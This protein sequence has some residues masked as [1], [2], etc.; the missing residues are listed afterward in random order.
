MRKQKQTKSAEADIYEAIKKICMYFYG[1]VYFKRDESYKETK[2]SHNANHLNELNVL[3][4]EM[5]KQ[6][7]LSGDS[8]KREAELNADSALTQLKPIKIKVFCI[9]WGLRYS[10]DMSLLS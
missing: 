2:Q 7:T 4:Y 8:L 6:H 9:R 3:I 1:N 10:A 5:L